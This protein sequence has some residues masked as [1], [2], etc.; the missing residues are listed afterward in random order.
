MFTHIDTDQ[1]VA[2]RRYTWPNVGITPNDGQAGVEPARFQPVR[3]VIVA[4]PQLRA[5][6]YDYLLV[7][8]AVVHQRATLYHGVGHDD[9]VANDRSLLDDDARR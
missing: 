3:A 6:T 9:R 4:G 1:N 7:N 8:D 2:A 5:L